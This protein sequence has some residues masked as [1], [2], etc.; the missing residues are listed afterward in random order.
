[1]LSTT[2]QLD[3]TETCERLHPTA[4]TPSSQGHTEHLPTCCVWAKNLDLD[5]TS[6]TKINSQQIVGANVKYASIKLAEVNI[7]EI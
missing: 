1:M 5:L 6:F 4:D 2:H 7:G 3:P